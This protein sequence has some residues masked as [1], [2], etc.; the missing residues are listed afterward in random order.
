MANLVGKVDKFKRAAIGKKRYP[1]IQPNFGFVE[2]A[3][4]KKGG[5]KVVLGCMNWVWVGRFEAVDGG[6]RSYGF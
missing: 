2:K 1:I 3:T 5:A 6:N 4:S